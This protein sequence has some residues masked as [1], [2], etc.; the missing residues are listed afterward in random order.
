MLGH[1]DQTDQ[2]E[3]VV[4]AEFAEDFDEEG[5]RADGAEERE[6]AVTT[7][8]DEVEVALTVAA[9]ESFS[10]GW[11]VPNPTTRKVKSFPPFANG[12][13]DGAPASSNSKARPRP[14]N[15]KMSCP[16][17][18]IPVVERSIVGSTDTKRWATRRHK[19]GKQGSSP[20]LIGCKHYLEPLIGRSSHE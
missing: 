4:R 16:S 13:K 11:K 17:G 3:L 8:G 5:A 9:L 10:H 6:S 7:A 19:S 2:R 1:D 12:A 14:I 15:Y 20:T 18:I